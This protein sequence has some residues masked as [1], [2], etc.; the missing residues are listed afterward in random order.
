MYSSS[1]VLLPE[2]NHLYSLILLHPMCCDSM[3]FD[4]FI[5]FFKKKYYKYFKHIK[6]IIPNADKMDINYPEKNLYNV[7]S[8]Y[9]YYTCYDGINKIDKINID[10]FSNNTKKIVRIIKNEYKI[11]NN[12]K[13]IFLYGVSQGG[14]LTFNI[15]K[16]LSKNIGALFISKS[17]YMKKYINLNINKETPIYIYTGL[18]DQIYNVEFQK[19]LIKYLEYKSYKIKWLIEKNIDH[20]IESYNEYNFIIKNLIININNQN[21]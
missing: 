4:N 5:N 11:I 3:F 13:N 7:Y 18:N 16:H 20:F 9:N 14:T 19:K 10:D 17:I 15:L 1:I 2:K 8:W 12:Y 6:F 21:N